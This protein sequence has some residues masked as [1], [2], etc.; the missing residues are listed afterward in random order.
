MCRHWGIPEPDAH[1]NRHRLAKEFLIDPLCEADGIDIGKFTALGPGAGNDVDDFIFL[2]TDGCSV[3]FELGCQFFE[4]S[5]LD[6][7]D[8][9]GL[10]G[11]AVDHAGP[12]LLC[13]FRNPP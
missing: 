1:L 10:A 13:D 4:S 3:L 11:R 2:G 7:G 6:M 8:F 12:V 5:G 9:D